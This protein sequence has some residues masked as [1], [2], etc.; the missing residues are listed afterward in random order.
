M[1]LHNLQLKNT[2]VV[3]VIC[4]EVINEAIENCLVTVSPVSMAELSLQAQLS[5]SY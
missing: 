5:L 2:S 3:E 4:K 1:F